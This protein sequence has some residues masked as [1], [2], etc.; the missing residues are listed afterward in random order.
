MTDHGDVSPV[1]L[2]LGQ[3]WCWVGRVFITFLL[4]GDLVSS[5]FLITAARGNK[6]LSKLPDGEGFNNSPNP[7][8]LFRSRFWATVLNSTWINK[9][10]RTVTFFL[11]IGSAACLLGKF[12]ETITTNCCFDLG[13]RTF[14]PLMMSGNCFK[15]LDSTY[16]EKNTSVQQYCLWKKEV[17]AADMLI[18]HNC[19]VY[20]QILL[21]P[22]L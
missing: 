16:R 22:G 4:D 18:N 9:I 15:R 14:T 17:R 5:A 3:E 21:Q 8:F 11:Y 10:K 20:K 7:K 2:L 12:C 19:N 6:T 13:F 1:S